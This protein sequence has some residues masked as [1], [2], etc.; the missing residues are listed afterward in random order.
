[1][2]RLPHEREPAAQRDHLLDASERQ[3]V[4]VAAALDE[5]DLHQREREGQ[6][7]DDLRAATRRAPH[8]E[9]AAERLHL[10]P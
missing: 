6:A 10:A 3:P 2:R 8:L 4:H 1:M 7:Q 5:H 9:I